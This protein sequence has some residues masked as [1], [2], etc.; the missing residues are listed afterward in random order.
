MAD[1]RRARAAALAE[2]QDELAGLIAKAE[3]L[4]AQGKPNVARIYL[5]MAA[6]KAVGP[7]KLEL[8]QRAAALKALPAR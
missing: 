5:Q 4:V 2:Q 3:A 1:A 8:E 7:R 6:G